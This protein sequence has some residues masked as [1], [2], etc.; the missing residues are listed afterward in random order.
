L[1]VVHPMRLENIMGWRLASHLVEQLD[2]RIST[3]IFV[4]GVLRLA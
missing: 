2:G 4:T 1:V 3:R